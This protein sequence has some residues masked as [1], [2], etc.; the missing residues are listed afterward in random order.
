MTLDKIFQQLHAIRRKGPIGEPPTREEF[1]ELVE[2][3]EDL[4]MK[5]SEEKPS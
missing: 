2:V 5:L 1:D 3:L 4:V